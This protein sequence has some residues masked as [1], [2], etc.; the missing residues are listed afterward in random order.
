MIKTVQIRTALTLVALMLLSSILPGC[1]ETVSD[2][3]EDDESTHPNAAPKEAMG[4]WWPTIDGVI[5]TPTIS[6]I[7]EWS[8]GDMIDIKF[9]DEASR[10]HPATL[11]YKSVE[12]GMAL[13]VDID[14]VEETPQQIVVTFPDRTLTT[15]I[16]A[17]SDAFVPKFELDC[18]KVIFDCSTS[19]SKKTIDKTD[20]MSV[21]LLHS[22]VLNKIA[23][24]HDLDDDNLV[25]EASAKRL[26]DDTTEITYTIDIVFEESTW[27]FTKVTDFDW[28]LP[29]LFPRSDISVT[30]IEV[31]Q[32]IQTAD[33]QMRLVEGKTSMARVY[34]DSGEL[35]TAN[36]QVTLNFC[37]LIF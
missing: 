4:M 29:F 31:T 14:D 7:T 6:P 5:E 24:I 12:E 13:A 20:L 37:I 21:E 36:V 11:R 8:D 23:S 28:V 16:T 25:M 35:E 17:E 27:T 30:G 19:E 9:T 32:A 1:L 15:E 10:E 26:F 22:L 3:I 2:V 34:V 18:T 33:M